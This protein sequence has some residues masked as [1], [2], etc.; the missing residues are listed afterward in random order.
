MSAQA[1]PGF[2]LAALAPCSLG[3][4]TLPAAPPFLDQP[5]PWRETL[6]YAAR[7]HASLPLLTLVSRSP[8]FGEIPPES[9][10]AIESA[11]SHERSILALIE[12]EHEHARALLSQAG[13]PCLTLKGVDLAR[14]FYPEPV[15]RP[16][17]DVDLLVPEER[18]EEAI[19]AFQRSGYAR[20]GPFPKGR[21]R[22]ELGRG[23]GAATVELHRRLQDGDT[24]SVT[25]GIWERAEGAG[26][27]LHVQ[28]LV[29]FLIRH[30]GVQHLLESPVW[31][32]DLHFVIESAEFRA[33][34][35]WEAL[36]RALSERSCLSAGWLLLT[37]LS[38]SCGTAIPAEVLA[39]LRGRA[40]RLRPRLL[41]RELEAWFP[42][43]GRKHGFV[44]SSR[45]LLRDRASEALAYALHRFHS[46]GSLALSPFPWRE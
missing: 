7:I 42:L 5:E 27:R 35:D 33:H 36:V 45:F 23:P 14:R 4:G 18:F 34:A 30:A 26:H 20:L 39:E 44:L 22:I 2:A 17:R 40:G 1:I 8:W 38:E 11:L 6:D 15:F 13:I 16:M 12:L 3:A 31:L 25:R 28:D 24:A 21:I 46:P 10:A 41:R 9:R 29:P 43:H 32:N 19:A 37:L